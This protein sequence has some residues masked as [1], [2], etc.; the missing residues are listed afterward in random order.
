MSNAK[1][2]R[3]HSAIEILESRVLLSASLLKQIKASPTYILAK[4]DANPAQANA[5]LFAAAPSVSP[6]ASPPAAMLLNPAQM[7]QAYGVNNIVFGS[8]VGNGTGETIAIVDAY[9]DPNASSNLATFDGQF[10][11][12]APPSFTQKSETGGSDSSV[13]TD[14]TGGWEV[15]ES[16][17]IEWAHSI[18]P[19]ANII[20]YEANSA[21]YSDLLTAVVT[22]AKNSNV[23]VVSM[24]WGGGEFSGET[25][26]DSDFTTPSSRASSGGV[27]FVASTGDSAAPAGY[28]AY[29]PNVVAVG[30]TTLLVSDTAGDYYSESGWSDGGGGTSTQEAEPNYQKSVQ[31][32]GFRDAPDVSM[33]ADPN[34]GVYVYDTFD[35]SGWLGVGGTSLASPMFAALVAIADQGRAHYGLKSLDGP[36]QTLPDLYTLPSTINFHDITTGSN[37]FSAGPG[38]DLV[39]GIGSPIANQLIPNLV[40]PDITSFV[41]SPNPVTAGNTLTLTATTSDVSG[42][43]STVAFYRESNG[44]SG[45]Q[46]GTGGDTFLGDGTFSSNAWTLPTSTTGLSGSQT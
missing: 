7:Q 1:R 19:D 16:L 21:S 12:S 17:D 9:R 6:A 3:K 15:E 42:T 34:S 45:L 8:T 41:A 27:T 29:S 46:T 33:D 25:S 38:Y 44:T 13:P 43:I 11:L 40:Q 26:Y 5:A 32:S 31:S 36:S 24:S 37:G 20:L 10:G 35:E 28:P 2:P 30:G 22:A 39:T 18:A 14:S 23:S 4:T